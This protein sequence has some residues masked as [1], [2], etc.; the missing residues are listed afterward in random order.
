MIKQY[1]NKIAVAA[2][3]KIPDKKTF[4]IILNTVSGVLMVWFPMV[5]T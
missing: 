1:E 3:N 2:N 5:M 4:D